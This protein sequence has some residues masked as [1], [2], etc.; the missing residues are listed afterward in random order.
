MKPTILIIEDDKE[1]AGYLAEK[2][3]EFYDT[4]VAD[5]GAK[6]LESLKNQ[7]A[8]CIILDL[9]LPDYK[10]VEDLPLLKEI[11]NKYS[12]IPVIIFTGR[13]DTS[14]AVKAAHLGAFD[15]L[16]KVHLDTDKLLTTVRNAVDKNKLQKRA[17]E[18]I[19]EELTGYPLI[20]KSRAVSKVREIIK[21]VA[22]SDEPVLITGE[23]GTGKEIVARHLHYY[24]NRSAENLITASLPGRDGNTAYSELFGHVKGAFTGA[25]Y[26]RDG[27]FQQADGGTLFLDDV[28]IF[29][30]DVQEML[31]RVIE[32]GIFKKLGSDKMVQ[33]DVRV[34]AS[35]NQDLK[36]LSDNN[37]FRKDLYFRLSAINI[38]LPPLRDRID[39]IS[40]LAHFFL[41]KELI[42]NSGRKREFSDQALAVLNEYKWPGNV[43]ELKQAVKR[44]FIMCDT[45]AIE[46]DDVALWLGLS[47]DEA[48]IKST[49]KEATVDFQR[50][51]VYQKLIENDKNISKTAQTLL[52]Y[53]NYFTAT[54]MWQ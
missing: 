9:G 13:D 33:V 17:K 50:Q 23:T 14:L 49:L 12:H 36:Q 54:F 28:D 22:S 4:Y 30:S 1:W 51:F 29:P 7:D 27:M 37:K 32:D 6:G 43:R 45:D 19:E 20:G 38:N 46:A 39:D 18:K 35:T 42:E 5:T 53:C 52:I 21:K 26:N 8:N 16:T 31:L 34:I 24:S 3:N 48:D 41:E 44:L 47:I 10:N 11:L 15:Y 40:L 2:L 25:D